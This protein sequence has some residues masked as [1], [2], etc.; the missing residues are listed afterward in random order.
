MEEGAEWVGEW[1]Q[2]NQR[3]IE[4]SALRSTSGWALH[5]LNRTSVGLKL[6]AAG[7]GR[8]D[9]AGLNRTSVGLKRLLRLKGGLGDVGL[10]RTSVGLKQVQ[11]R[12][13]GE[14]EGRPQSNQRGIET[15]LGTR[16]DGEAWVGLNRTS[17]GLKLRAKMP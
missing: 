12:Q 5:R 6:K 4:T 13:G 15:R 1:P 16:I 14:V 11:E 10:N 3:G 2:S 7:E 9:E 17:V 8:C